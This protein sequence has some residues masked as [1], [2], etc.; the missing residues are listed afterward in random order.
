MANILGV[1][2]EVGE[3]AVKKALTS[4]SLFKKDYH[5]IGKKKIE[6]IIQKPTI[7]IAGRPYV[8][9]PS[10]VNLALPKM[11]TSRG[12]NVI[13][14]DMLPYLMEEKNQDRNVWS[15]TQQIENAI[16]YTQMNPNMYICLLSCFSCGPDSIMYHHFR[17]ELEGSIFCYLEIDSHT[18]HAGFE[19]RVEAF[20]D[21]IEGRRRNLNY[22]L[23]MIENDRIC[24]Y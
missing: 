17:Q 8:V 3:K 10:E 22:K 9:Y 1:E 20:L 15:F 4:Y 24:S 6:E 5:A 23:N 14:A 7:I 16:Q 2:K 13:P 19:T 21:I 12:Y 18:A 11:I